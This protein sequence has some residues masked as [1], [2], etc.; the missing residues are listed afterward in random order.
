MPQSASRPPSPQNAAVP[1]AA[2]WPPTHPELIL[3]VG[4]HGPRH[5]VPQAAPAGAGA[6]ALGA[7]PHNVFI[8]QAGGG[9]VALPAAAAGRYA[10]ARARARRERTSKLAKRQGRIMVPSTQLSSAALIALG[11]APAAVALVATES[12]AAR[13]RA[14]SEVGS[15]C[16]REASTPPRPHQGREANHH[17]TN[18]PRTRCV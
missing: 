7:L 6:A 13:R 4:G 10:A 5:L 9:K 1:S 15:G 12:V 18:E 17:S 2:P 3:C 11:E 8:A 14:V 16:R